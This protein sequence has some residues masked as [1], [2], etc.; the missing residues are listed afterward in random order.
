MR[1][2]D[3][4]NRPARL[5]TTAITLN[6]EHA[7]NVSFDANKITRYWA[8]NADNEDVYS[9]Y[10]SLCEVMTKWDVVNDDGTPYPLTPEAMG[11]LKF[12]FQEDQAILRQLVLAA[13]PSS[14]EG[15][16]SPVPSS[17]PPSVSSELPPTSQN[18]QATSPAPVPSASPSPT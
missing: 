4:Q 9:F 15:K 11:E 16:A 8:K 3:R 18:G 13:Q 7:F 10:K 1:V 2:S 12:S 17:T 5:V 14:E 6:D